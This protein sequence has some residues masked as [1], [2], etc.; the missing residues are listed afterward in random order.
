VREDAATGET[1]KQKIKKGREFGKIVFFDKN[2]GE[3]QRKQSATS[4]G[5]SVSPSV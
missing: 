3:F 4:R 2:F 1:F 5:I